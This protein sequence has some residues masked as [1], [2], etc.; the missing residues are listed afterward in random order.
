MSKNVILKAPTHI[1]LTITE[2]C[3]HKCKHCYNAWREKTPK[4]DFFDKRKINHILDELIKCQVTYVTLTGGEP[5]LCLD[6]MFYII[7]ELKELGIGVG[8]NT[9]LSLMT[10]SI[11]KILKEKYHWENTIL[12]SLPG[13]TEE[14]CDK[15]TQI[16]GSFGLIEKG[17]EICIANNIPVG[18]NVVITKSNLNNL[19]DLLDFLDRHNV[20][21]LA[22]T[23]V[24]PPVYDSDN[25]NFRLS[26]EDVNKMVDFLRLVKRKY[27]ISVTS[28]CSLPLC[29]LDKEEDLE[30]FSTKCAAGIITCSINGI[31][32]EVTPCAHNDISYGNIYEKSLFDIWE[33][34]RLWRTGEYL[35]SECENCKLI[36]LCGG[37]CRL[38]ASR[39]KNKPYHLEKRNLHKN[40][41]QE[42]VF[43]MKNNIKYSFNQK[44]FLRDEEF[45]AVVSLGN[46]EFYVTHSVKDFILILRNKKEFTLEDIL[47]ICEMND[48]M[49]KLLNQMLIAE[50]LYE[51]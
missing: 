19:N 31:T 13:F 48:Y 45:G 15:I 20:S 24:V 50:I 2:M 16:K 49:K 38:N 14:E 34:M 44:T 3:N 25:S 35:P 1:E 29:L 9:N 43:L 46:N 8:L 33:N 51:V 40:R 32:G 41:N 37:D 28:L 18:I 21:V 47:L 22:L 5:L 26:K 17:I 6:R 10:D 42:N 39:F 12:T 7:G 30:L 4:N 23:R 27:K 36:T 11:A